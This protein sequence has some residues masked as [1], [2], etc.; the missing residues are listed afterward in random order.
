MSFYSDKAVTT[1]IS[2]CTIRKH[3]PEECVGS[4]V[5]DFAFRV[6]PVQ[7]LPGALLQDTGSHGGTHRLDWAVVDML[8]ALAGVV[9]CGH[10]AS[11]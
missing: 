3:S 8:G 9:G 11:F 2:I 7:V 6:F 5:I 4:I 10:A 1:P